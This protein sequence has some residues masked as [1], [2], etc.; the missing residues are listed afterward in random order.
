[1]E[2]FFVDQRN[3]DELIFIS[4]LKAEYGNLVAS[5][6]LDPLETT[7]AMHLT[8]CLEPHGGT[9]KEVFLDTAI[10]FKNCETG[11]L[12]SFATWEGVDAFLDDLLGEDRMKRGIGDAE[13]DEIQRVIDVLEYV[14]HNPNILPED[15]LQLAF[16]LDTLIRLVKEGDA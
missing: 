1:M 5:G 3:P 15:K 7:F 8:N 11:E 9:L 4:T 13:R 14:Y 6:D 12:R 10:P 2:R 16:C